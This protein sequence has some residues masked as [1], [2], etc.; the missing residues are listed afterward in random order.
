VTHA[1]GWALVD[2]SQVVVAALLLTIAAL[3]AVAS[4]LSIPYP[5]VLV[6]GGLAIGL[7]PG[8]PEIELDP[9]LVLFVFLPPLLYSGAFFADLPA[10]RRDARTLVLTALGLVLLTTAVV[11]V[12]GHAFLGLTW[13][14]AFA[15]G[16]IVSPTDPLAAT[17][18]MRRLGVQRRI[19]NLVEGESLI[20]DAAALVTY[21][22]AVAAAVAGSFSLATATLE[23]IAATIGGVAIGLLVGWAVRH[24]RRRIDDPLTSITVSLLTGYAAYVPA[25]ALDMSGV[26]ATVTAGIYLGWRSHE[27]A[28]PGVR[29][30]ATAVWEV[31]NFLLN[32]TLF[33]LVGLQLRVVVDG[34]G[35][36]SPLR[37]LRDALMVT[38][39]IVAVRFAWMFSVPYLVRLVD[40]R[41]SQRARRVGPGPRVVIAWSG[42]R[43]GVSMAAALA[44]P[45][46][47]DAEEPL[48]GRELIVFVAFVVVLVT[49]VVQGLTLP[50]LAR[51]MGTTVG[52]D[53]ER[54]AELRARLAASKAALAEL[55][56]IAADDSADA[57]PSETVD[58]LRQRFEARKRR[59]AT[60]A[61]IID[62]G[63][64][65]DAVAR[66]RVMRQLLQAQR[67]TLVQLR[68][69]GQISND[70]MH[71]L[72]RELD[73][74]ESQLDS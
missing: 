67:R 53:S 45:L 40:R 2:G 62:D 12:V 31:L 21:R 46:T 69:S 68:N 22:V 50:T 54:E 39:T 64:D 18:I 29:L 63:R 42:L 60:L 66:R 8:M 33:I 57:P 5:I 7:V 72:Q 24:V 25:E 32:A 17:A 3:N 56:A 44:L 16:A 4:R 11:A 27:L 48:P 37:L 73:L 34:L 49:V 9:E 15:L 6:V 10:L 52:T 30:Q 41:P 1:A 70:V 74:E 55:E 59:D 58:R 38:I 28:A 51:R 43:G 14:M 65:A 19:V 13:P 47:T 36:Q 20:N 35:D 61:G 23:F 26:L 71:L